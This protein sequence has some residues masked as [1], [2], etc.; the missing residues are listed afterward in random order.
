MSA[1]ALIFEALIVPYRSLSRKGLAVVVGILSAATAAV[2]L[3][4]WLLGAWP[5]MAFSL[6]EAPLILLLLTINSRRARARELIM[7]DAYEL[8]V[9]R[10]D[11]GGRQERVSLPS[12]WLRVDLD[13]GRG[14]PR[15]LMSSRG[16]RYEIGAFLHEPE[17]R[18]LFE[19]LRVALRRAQHP[20]FDNPQLRE[21]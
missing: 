17:K 11:A 5:V 1:D 20:Q 4:F 3:R 9:I 19:A 8:T 10:T 18:S 14:M 12:A 16:R 21:G 6:V 7:L 13:T 2:A 15:L